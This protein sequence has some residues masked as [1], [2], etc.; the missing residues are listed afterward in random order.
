MRHII[1]LLITTAAILLTSCGD[2]IYTAHSYLTGPVDGVGIKKTT[3]IISGDTERLYPVVT[4]SKTSNKNVTWSS[5]DETVASVDSTGLVTAVAAVNEGETKSAVITVTTEE[6]N[7]KDTCTVTVVEKPIPVDSL[8]LS[9]TASSLV[10]NTPGI[11]QLTAEIHPSN[12][13]NQQLTWNSSAPDTV[14]VDASGLVT[15]KQPGTG[16]ITVTAASGVKATC[17]YTI[18]SEPVSV[19]GIT[20]NKES[21]VIETGASE[22]IF[23]TFTPVNATNRTLTWTSTNS[24]IASVD[25]TGLVRGIAA[26][27]A[28]IKATSADGGFIASCVCTVTASAVKAT[29]VTLNTTALIITAGYTEQ[30]SA[31]ISPVDSNGKSTAT[32][33]GIAW[34]SSDLNVASVDSS[35]QVI[36]IN[37]GSAT[38]TATTSDGGFIANC[39]CMVSSAIIYVNNVTLNKSTLTLGLGQTETLFA[40]VSPAFAS[41]RSV[42][43]SSSNPSV[44]TVNGSGTV[45]A[46]ITGTATI[47]ATTNDGGKTSSCLCTVS[48]SYRVIYRNNG[49]SGEVP[50]PGYYTYGEEVTVSGNTGG[51][52]KTG[53]FL[54][55]WNTKNNGSGTQYAPGSTFSMGSADVILYAM[56]KRPAVTYYPGTGNTGGSVPAVTEHNVNATVTVS[57]NTGN[58]KGP[59]LAENLPIWQSFVKWNSK[60]DGTGTDYLAGSTFAITE[61]VALYAIYTTDTGVLRKRGPA[62]GWIFYVNPNAATDG[63]TYLE[64]ASGVNGWKRWG[65]YDIDVDTSPAIG[66]GLQ[67]TANILAVDSTT[68]SAAKF[69]DSYSITNNGTLYDDWFLPSTDEL[70]KLIR[71]LCSGT[72]ENGVTFSAISENFYDINYSSHDTGTGVAPFINKTCGS[73]NQT[74]YSEGTALPVRRF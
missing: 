5:S 42:T 54:S 41:D 69:C 48:S 62:G 70:I 28:T 29:G 20:L 22:R 8:T 34:K 18:L 43:W 45:T 74:K 13:T 57:N 61:D 73:S 56:W 47:T 32:N 67:N 58:L 59:L 19:T 15:A 30:L 52:V 25:S 9:R 3:S 33:Q 7:F 63:W 51:L 53:Y 40:Q 38:I 35:G 14:S 44:A 49:S 12:A 24:G 23:A 21:T 6:G 11:E 46:K 16:V 31:V 71:N 60:P 66:Y 72:D 55:G 27:T 65:A 37:A 17:H 4:P 26:G 50:D 10:V 36:A 2:S 64:M 68:D 1:I 39:T